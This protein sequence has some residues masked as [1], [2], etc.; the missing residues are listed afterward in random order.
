MFIITA[1]GY[2]VPIYMHIKVS[3][4]ICYFFLVKK[5]EHKISIHLHMKMHLNIKNNSQ[6]FHRHNQHFPITLWY[7]TYESGVR[8]V[9]LFL[10]ATKQLY[11]HFFP[12]F[13]PSV[14]LSVRLWHLFHYVPAIVSSWNFQNLLPLTEV[15]YMRKVKVRGE[16]SRSQRSWSHLAVSGL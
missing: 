14:C 10:A 3:L 12:S 15:M 11:E 5:L 6:I 1:V 16:R 4:I 8:A 9:K 2:T 7:G 13:C